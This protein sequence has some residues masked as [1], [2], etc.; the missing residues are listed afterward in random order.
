VRSLDPELKFGEY[1]EAY[2]A[3]QPLVS[4]GMRIA[5]HEA[6]FVPFMLDVENIDM[7]GLTSSFVGSAPTDDAILTDVGRHY[8]LTPE[9]PHH[10]VHAYLLYRQPE[11]IVVRR[12]WMATANAG[13]VAD[14]IFQGYYRAEKRTPSFV[15]Y[16]R[17][18]RPIEARRLKPDAFLENLAHPAYAERIVL[19]GIG[20]DPE[21]SAAL[22][23]LWQRRKHEIVADPAWTLQ[24]DPREPGPV[25]EIYL[26][27]SAPSADVI[28]DVRLKGGGPHGSVKRLRHKAEAGQALR[29]HEALEAP[30]H[31]DAIEMRLTSLTGEAVRVGLVAV[32]VMGQSDELREHVVRHGI[33]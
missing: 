4:P 19:N 13:R 8:P 27:A 21:A 17:S 7:L 3:L 1:Y 2:R 20:V 22:P 33:R 9:P 26:E 23:P 11:L 28:V 12:S 14:E 25:H 10:A 16:R 24:I 32:R 18:D 31:T 5:Y 30:H 15:I 6:G 29:F